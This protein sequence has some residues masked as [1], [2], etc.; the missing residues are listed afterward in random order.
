ML[1]L[2]KRGW[3]TNLGHVVSS[4]RK[5]L[6]I[7]SPFMTRDGTEFIL[8]Q[9]H[10]EFRASGRIEILVNLSPMN[11]IQGA[12]DPH[13][14]IVLIERH[15]RCVIHHLPRLHAK[16]YVSDGREAIITSGNLTGGGLHQNF[17]YGVHVS[18]TLTALNVRNDM[19]EYA[20]LGATVT[21]VQLHTYCDA[22]NK[23]QIAYQEQQVAST[24]AAKDKFAEAMGIANDELIRL[25]L[26]GETTNTIFTRTILYLLRQHGE[27]STAV[28]NS[29][30]QQ[31]HPDLCDETVDRVIDGKHYGKKW[32]HAVRSAQQGL[33]RTGNIELVNQVWRLTR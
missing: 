7:A 3:S 1:E 15:P 6:V 20:I 11:M 24:T 18:D 12:T 23:A 13:A 19:L 17:E 30:I 9:L 28:I 8:A 14:I 16:V 32:K 29:L 2:L 25:R 27:L 26:S 22:A 33:K 31:L 21:N 10:P 5:E 4:A